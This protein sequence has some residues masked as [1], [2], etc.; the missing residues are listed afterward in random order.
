MQEV[1]IST[2]D[3]YVKA[4]C[5]IRK[6]FHKE[7]P[8]LNEVPLFRGQADVS[9]ELLPSIARGRHSEIDITIFNE[10]RNLLEMAKYKLP[11]IFTDDLKPIE[12]LALAQHHGIPTRLLDVTENALVALYFACASC[13]D[14]DG[15][16]IVFKENS[17]SVTIIRFCKPLQTPIDCAKELGLLQQ[18]LLRRP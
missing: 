17:K 16:V 10:E 14:K 3:E 11:S 18:T 9:Y 2:V 6:T 8:M 4:I 7:Y 13:G 5:D 15:E 1:S 12:L